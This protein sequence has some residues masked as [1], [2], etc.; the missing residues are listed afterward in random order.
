MSFAPKALV[1]VITCRHCKGTGC[2]Y[3]QDQGVHGE[4]EGQTLVFGIPLFLAVR[5][6]KKALVIFWLKR[7]ALYFL[8]A[9]VVWLIWKS[10]V[11]NH[12]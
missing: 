10:L 7:G 8:T 4:M 2:N 12:F 6:R 5:E 11:F 1:N 3:C 9:L